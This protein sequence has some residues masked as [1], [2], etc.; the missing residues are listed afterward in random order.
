M[1]TGLYWEMCW[2][3][4]WYCLNW[5]SPHHPLVPE[6][7]S[8]FGLPSLCLQWYLSVAAT[9]VRLICICSSAAE[10]CHYIRYI[11]DMHPDPMNVLNIINSIHSIRTYINST[12]NL[13]PTSLLIHHSFIFIE[14]LRSLSMQNTSGVFLTIT[15]LA[16][17]YLVQYKY[18]LFNILP[19][20]SH[21]LY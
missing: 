4:N 9:K 18:M 15:R 17:I 7:H 19:Y 8:H 6:P 2:M 20:G 10:I 1:C 12:S 21:H 3:L 16:G 5:E 13:Y 11:T 14:S